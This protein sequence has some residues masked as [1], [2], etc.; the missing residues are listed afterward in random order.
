MKGAFFSICLQELQNKKLNKVFIFDKYCL[1]QVDLKKLG[2]PD[3]KAEVLL[4][5]LIIFDIFATPNNECFP[6]TSK[7]EIISV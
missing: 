6:L 2:R 7:W 1:Q 5:R 3:K 4:W